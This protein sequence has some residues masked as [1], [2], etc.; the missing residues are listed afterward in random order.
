[1]KK[2]SVNKWTEAYKELEKETVVEWNGNELHIKKTISYPEMAQ[3]VSEVSGVCFDEH[4]NY[5][6]ENLDF[7][8]RAGIVMHYSNLTVP[9][10]GEKAYMLL[11]GTDA[12]ETVVSKV[13]IVQLSA[14]RE[15][16]EEK[17]EYLIETRT[18]QIASAIE[19]I[20][21]SVNEVVGKIRET[22]DSIGSFDAEQVKS[23]M[24]IITESGSLDEAKI[25][26]ALA[27]K[28]LLGGE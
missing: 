10:D 1:M 6:P 24:N 15:A 9:T 8:C 25:V 7:A 20:R 4:G 26:E 21:A 17:I 5:R 23:F 2:I 13:N 19:E 28:G 14:I 18:K 22:A 12:Y 27:E 16:I 11:Y 3:I